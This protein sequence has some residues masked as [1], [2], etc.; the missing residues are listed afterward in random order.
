MKEEFISYLYEKTKAYGRVKRFHRFE[1]GEEVRKGWEAE[2]CKKV[3]DFVERPGIGILKDLAEKRLKKAEEEGVKASGRELE[4]LVRFLSKLGYKAGLEL[5]IAELCLKRAQM[6]KPRG[7]GRVPKKENFL[8]E[9]LKHINFVLAQEKDQNRRQQAYKLKTAVYLELEHY[10]TKPKDFEEVLKTAVK[11]AGKT[12]PLE[13]L[14]SLAERG[15]EGALK[16]AQEKALPQMEDSFL[17]ARLSLLERKEEEAKK[18][19]LKA[20]KDKKPQSFSDPFWEEALDFAMRLS[21]EARYEVLKK[22]WAKLREVE[23]NFAYHNL[24]LL[25]YW[26]RLKELYEAVFEEVVN[27]PALTDGACK[28]CL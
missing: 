25:W 8:K 1:L 3:R 4:H 19:F 11:E 26:S 27:Y 14:L 22:L 13:V 28:S 18:L 9:A 23:E 12:L 15:I 5:Y 20:L 7:F 24:H 17:K 16:L 21:C 2:T 6:L 10:G